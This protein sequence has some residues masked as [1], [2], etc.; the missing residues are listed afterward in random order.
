MN[1]LNNETP[2]TL[3][4]CPGW[5]GA[6]NWWLSREANPHSALFN[7]ISQSSFF[8]CTRHRKFHASH[9]QK[10]KKFL[11]PLQC[12]KY[13]HVRTDKHAQTPWMASYLPPSPI[14][15]AARTAKTLYP[16][17][18]SRSSFYFHS[19][20]HWPHPNVKNINTLP[21]PSSHQFI[22][23]H[24]LQTLNR[25]LYIF[26]VT[27]AYLIF[28]VF[29]SIPDKASPPSRPSTFHSSPPVCH[30]CIT[31]PRSQTTLPA[32]AHLQIGRSLNYQSKVGSHTTSAILTCD[33]NGIFVYAI[34]PSARCLSRRSL[35][36]T[37][38][39]S[40]ASGRQVP[41]ALLHEQGAAG[42]SY[43]ARTVPVHYFPQA[44]VT[45]IQPT[46]IRFLRHTETNPTT[47][48]ARAYYGFIIRL[49]TQ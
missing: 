41:I 2:R 24:T 40:I 46:A 32:L 34:K 25:Q 12:T 23:S 20:Q 6:P 22:H 33:R 43:C 31:D 37:L 10:E 28:K 26:K 38:Y 18:P 30:P 21:L 48:K 27:R 15:T 3:Q 29:S 11:T 19:C 7:Q 47:S 39:S 8:C 14:S 45:N 16:E 13:K 17:L 44:A 42:T 4:G 5:S 9:R 35:W 49:S 36:V 1:H